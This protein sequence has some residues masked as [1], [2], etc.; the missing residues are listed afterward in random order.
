MIM[1]E[2]KEVKVIDL[3]NETLTRCKRLHEL[4]YEA[5]KSEED[6]RELP[7]EVLMFEPGEWEAIAITIQ[8]LQHHV[9]L[10]RKTKTDEEREKWFA[11][12]GNFLALARDLVCLWEC[13]LPRPN[14]A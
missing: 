7:N 13:R 6:H 9:K 10:L 3:L 4:L 1:N 14:K 2:G 12:N 11:E 8:H 5:S